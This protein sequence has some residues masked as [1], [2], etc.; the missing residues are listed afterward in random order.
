MTVDNGSGLVISMVFDV[1]RA[2]NMVKY[3]YENGRLAK[4]IETNLLKQITTETITYKYFTE[5]NFHNWT[6]MKKAITNVKGT[7][8]VNVTRQIEYYK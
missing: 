6:K 3:F 4:S 7:R 2:G 1:C 5:D 8:I